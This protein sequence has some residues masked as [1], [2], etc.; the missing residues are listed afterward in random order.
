MGLLMEQ[1]IEKDYIEN[2]KGNYASADNTLQWKFIR[3]IE[4]NIGKGI[5][6]I[7]SPSIGKYP[8]KYKKII[9]KTRKWSNGIGKENVRIGF[10]NLGIIKSIM[11]YIGFKNYLGR[12]IESLGN[13]DITLIS[14]NTLPFQMKAIKEIKNK[15]NNVNIILIV[16]DLPQYTYLEENI[17]ITNKIRRYIKNEGL[18]KNLKYIDGFIAL[19]KGIEEKVNK[20]K[21]PFMIIEG[22]ASEKK[23][24][25][26]K[27]NDEEKIIL[28]TGTLRKKYGI[29][30]LLEAFKDIEFSKYKLYIC[31]K[32]EAE[33]DIKE[34]AISDKRIVYKGLVTQEEAIRL[35]SIATV[36]VNPRP[37]NDDFIKY[38]FPSKTIEYL[39]SGKPVICHRL[40]C[41]P[42]DYD[43]YLFYIND[44]SCRALKEKIIEVCEMSSEDRHKVGIRGQQFINTQ[45]SESVQ[46][47]KVIKL[48]ELL[49]E[50]KNVY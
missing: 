8:N 23:M 30:T 16:P 35:Q 34:Y 46:G 14:Y 15:Y 38:S 49:R 28:Y 10:V 11:R 13:K 43:E 18:Y 37:N 25:L 7:S 22:I 20:Y 5:Y 17:S 50:K 39:S 1:D 40:D 47:A 19:T 41:I 2:I 6:I 48:A 45:K 12:L 31:G 26:S 42:S 33:E 3:G 4:K 29:M 9:I 36:L 32:G 44:L 27:E 21:K 24:V